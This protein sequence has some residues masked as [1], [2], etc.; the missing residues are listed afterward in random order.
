MSLMYPGTLVWT[1]QASIQAALQ[2][3]SSLLSITHFLGTAWGKSRYMAFLFPTPWSNS[4]GIMTG[5]PSTQRP[6][7]VHLFQSTKDAFLLI[8]TLNFPIPPETFSPS[9]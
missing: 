6:H 7:P 5:H 2:G 3:R 1:G 9:E 8:L 4:F